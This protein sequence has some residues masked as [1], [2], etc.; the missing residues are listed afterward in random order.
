MAAANGATEIGVPERV[1]RKHLSDLMRRHAEN[2]TG[3]VV[4]ACP[5]GCEDEELDENGYCPHLI[6]FATPNDKLHEK[7]PSM[8]EPLVQNGE[9]KIVVGFKRDAAGKRVPNLFPLLKGDKIVRI[10]TSYR[11]YRDV[12]DP[13]SGAKESA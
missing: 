6:G 1:R 9:H 5:Y 7:K 12:S 2:T 13:K 3:G 4:N 11:V 8:Y 10:T